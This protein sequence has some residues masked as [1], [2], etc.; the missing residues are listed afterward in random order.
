MCMLFPV[1]SGVCPAS[2]RQ[3]KIKGNIYKLKADSTI[4]VAALLAGTAA[5][6]G[7]ANQRDKILHC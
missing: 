3:G 2:N 6:L 5:K 4:T 1:A 7:L